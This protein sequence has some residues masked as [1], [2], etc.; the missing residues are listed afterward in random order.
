MARGRRAGRLIRPLTHCG[1]QAFARV[2]LGVRE[3]DAVSEELDPREVGTAV[4]AALEAAGADIRWRVP[5]DQVGAARAQATDALIHASGRAFHAAKEQLAGLSPARLASVDGRGAR[6]ASHWTGYAEGRVRSERDGPTDE[7]LDLCAREHP[8]TLR[9]LAALRANVP[10]HPPVSDSALL[11]WLMRAARDA[12]RGDWPEDADQARGAG[13]RDALPEAWGPSLLAFTA[14]R[15]GTPFH[16]M[17]AVIWRLHQMGAVLAHAV[18]QTWVEVGF[19]ADARRPGDLGPVTLKLGD[20]AL[21]VRGRIDRVTRVGRWLQIVDYKSGGAK[22]EKDAAL[23]GGLVT[24]KDPQLVVYALALLAAA[25]R[26]AGIP[27]DSRPEVAAVGW[28]HVRHT[29]DDKRKPVLARDQFLLE[30]GVTDE[31]GA[32]LGRLV[33]AAREGRWPLRPRPDT[34]PKLAYHHDRCPYASA[35]RFRALPEAG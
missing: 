27:A 3:P 35:C 30:R 26:L 16:R 33:A 11:S 5:E 4:H 22:P 17:A 7:I 13:D 2:I 20:Q 25:D 12:S 34:C 23:W 15:T 21:A 31:L 24:L 6:W 1:W 29:R 9:A 14:R 8:A 28:D 19:G 32:G 18:D 10:E